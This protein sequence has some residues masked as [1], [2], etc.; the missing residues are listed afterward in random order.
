ML[1]LTRISL[2]VLL[3]SPLLSAQTLSH[4]RLGEDARP[5]RAWL[6]DEGFDLL[7]GPDG[8]LELIVGEGEWIRLQALGLE[9]ERIA[10][11]R[12]F[13][14][15]QEERQN[16]SGVPAGYPDL[17]EVL[18][19]MS[20]AASNFPGICEI[21]EINVLLGTPA[22]V[23]GR[24][25]FACKISDQVDV[26]EDEPAIL[27][28]SAHHC[29]ELV[30]PV[31]A[32]HAI[33]QLT[34]LY[35]SDPTVTSVVDNHEIW[36]LPV[37][38]PD[39][40]EYVFD[41]DN[42]WRKNRNPGVSAVGVDL[43]RN[44]PFGWTSACSGSTSE[45]SCT[46]KGPSAGSESEVQ[47]I[48]ALSAA[49]RFDKVLDFHS[50]GREILWGY[51][52]HTHPLASYLMTEGTAISCA[53]GYSGAERP[54]T[55]EGEHF[56]WQLAEY[57]N[58]AFLLE[59][60]SQFQPSFC[61]AESEAAQVWGGVLS[62]LSLE[63]PLSGHVF[64]ACTGE[65]LDADLSF[66]G[67]N[68]VNGENNSSGGIFGRYHAFLPPGNYQVQFAATGYET[69]NVPVT[70]Q[71]GL[72]E[73]REVAMRPDHFLLDVEPEILQALDAVEFATCGGEAGN[74]AMLFL[75][76]INGSPLFLPVASGTLDFTGSWVLPAIVP[77]DPSLPGNSVTVRS[78]SVDAFGT[79][80]SSND[81]VLSFP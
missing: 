73:L 4:V 24:G 66:S 47:A 29:R 32:L 48:M 75:V 77:N 62:L 44:Y 74:L 61:S 49:Q 26:D 9:I 71:A 79:L 1:T 17:S 70:I 31:I 12:P 39:G 15:I 23:E 8:P 43:N 27:L 35:G 16:F 28:V 68:Y 10:K 54:P 30:T 65:P 18:A 6:E 50:F 46:Y 63:I 22:T 21:V 14:E 80:L 5:L 38:N 37:C 56:E 55:A 69:R 42:L 25:L 59:T 19:A 13:R 67:V 53:A 45:S 2:A 51:A 11:G 34:N 7:Y 36:I 52:C 60:H 33:D 76:A 3:C 72:P 64:D 57:G 81:E 40:Y 58:L 78:L 20:Q 41:V